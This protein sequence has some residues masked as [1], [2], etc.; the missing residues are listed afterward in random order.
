MVLKVQL[1][2][3]DLTKHFEDNFQLTIQAIRIAKRSIEAGHEVS[4]TNLLEELKNNPN[5]Q[6]IIDNIEDKEH[7]DG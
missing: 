1:T 2:N 6:N 5:A 3:E 7:E 4:L